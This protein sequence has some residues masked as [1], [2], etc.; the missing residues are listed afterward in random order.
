M[1]NGML[2]IIPIIALGSMILIPIPGA[3]LLFYAAS[4][5]V[6]VIQQRKVLDDDVEE[7]E[8]I[9]DKADKPV[10]KAKSGNKKASTKKRAEE[11][12]EAE[13]VG[14]DTTE[15]KVKKPVQK[16]RKGSKVR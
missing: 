2:K 11:A 16:R 12:V 1:S 13:V 7:M 6:A 8:A 14:Q 5:I 10:K 9:A 15:R 4:S 3:L